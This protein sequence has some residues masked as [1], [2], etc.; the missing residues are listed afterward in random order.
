[1][2]RFVTHAVGFTIPVII[3]LVFFELG[4]NEVV[5]SFNFKRDNLVKKADSIQLLIVG[6]SQTTFGVNP[7]YFSVRSFNLANPSQS[8]YYD[9]RLV[10]NNLSKLPQLKCVV[11]TV[12]YFS[13][14]YQ[15]IDGPE[16]WRD[17]YYRQFWDITYE[18]IDRWDLRNYSKMALYK[19]DTALRYAMRNFNVAL[20]SR[21]SSNGFYKRDTIGNNRRI[22]DS[23]GRARVRFHDH[24]FKDDQVERNVNDLKLLLKQLKTHNIK[25][26]LIT[27]PVWSSYS[28]YADSDRLRSNKKII[29]DI[30]SSLGCTYLNYFTDDRFVKEDFY[31][32]DHLNYLGAEKFTKMLDK[33]IFGGVQ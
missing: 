33:E 28:R 30:C 21:Y 11:L 14:G 24:Y 13:F 2:K 12:S 31:D 23:L 7:S 1:V 10:L 6:S 17:F 20:A 27:P 4:L 22:N 8:I 15:V 16:N 18:G 25:T 32:N 19:P 5:N 26:I 3:I 29:D 9:T